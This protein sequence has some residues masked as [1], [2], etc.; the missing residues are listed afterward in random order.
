MA[1]TLIS[2]ICCNS[3]YFF[4]HRNKIVYE[5]LIQWLTRILAPVGARIQHFYPNPA[6]K[7]YVRSW[8]P[9][10]GS[11]IWKNDWVVGFYYISGLVTF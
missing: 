4:L 2:N 11:E 8:P 7:F 5:T 3:N 10:D 1:R 6:K 9:L